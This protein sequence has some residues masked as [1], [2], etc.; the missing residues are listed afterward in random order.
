M[1]LRIEIVAPDPRWPEAFAAA[2]AELAGVP[3]LVAIEHVGST[4][5]P[6]L[7]AKPI[8]DLAG[9]VTDPV[10]LDTSAEEAWRADR[11][12]SIAPAG[13][14]AHVA[15]VE[16]ITRLGYVYRGHAEIPGRLYFRRDTGGRRSEH[17]HVS[18]LG[19]PRWTENLD[20]RDYLRAHPERADAYAALKRRLAVEHADRAAYT[21]AKAPFIQ[22]TLA[23]ARAWRGAT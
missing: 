7:A 23:L 11:S 8:V 1:A 20:F 17:L 14:P 3:G 15:L 5:V 16:A 22:E 9:G 13:A 10:I 12:H 4:S 18:L 21:D 6:G 2:R 19:G